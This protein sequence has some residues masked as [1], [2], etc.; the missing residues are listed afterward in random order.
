LTLRI[1]KNIVAATHFNFDL[2]LG[3]IPLK[4]DSTGNLQVAVG[5]DYDNLHF[6]MRNSHYFW[7]TSR[8]DELK[9][10]LDVT[11]PPTTT[12]GP[13]PTPTTLTG[14]LGFLQL[15][16]TDETDPAKPHTGLHG[17]F[18]LDMTPTGLGTNKLTGQADVHL[19]VN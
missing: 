11:V 14:T 6:G 18:T 1:T 4:V 9:I 5:F 2:G 12:N 7:D 8:L 10:T 17:T 16:A 15:T 19:N 3:G 13:N